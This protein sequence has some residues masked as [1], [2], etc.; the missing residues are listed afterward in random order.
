MNDSRAVKRQKPTSLRLSAS[1]ATTGHL[2]MATDKPYPPPTFRPEVGLYEQTFDVKNGT[3]KRISGHTRKSQR[4]MQAVGQTTSL[5]RWEP[6]RCYDRAS[7]RWGERYTQAWG[8]L[9]PDYNLRNGSCLETRPPA[10]L[11]AAER[12]LALGVVI[13]RSPSG[14]WVSCDLVEEIARQVVGYDHEAECKKWVEHG[15]EAMEARAQFVPARQHCLWETGAGP[16]LRFTGW[17][18][19]GSETRAAGFVLHGSKVQSAHGRYSRELRLGLYDG[20][21]RVVDEH[22]GWP[23]LMNQAEMY[24]FQELLD[25]P[26]E[27]GP[28][29][30]LS[31]CWAPTTAGP[32]SSEGYMDAFADT[33]VSDGLFVHQYKDK[34]SLQMGSFNWLLFQDDTDEW[35]D[36]VLTTTLLMTE[37]DVSVAEERCQDIALARHANARTQLDGVLAVVI[38]GIDDAAQCKAIGCYERMPDYGPDK[39]V[40]FQQVSANN[41][42][43]HLY[44]QA[45]CLEW[46]FSD[47]GVQADS[48]FTYCGLGA[49]ESGRLPLSG[50]GPVRWIAGPPG[51]VNV[52]ALRGESAQAIIAQHR[53]KCKEEIAATLAN[54]RERM[55]GVR[56][57]QVSCC[58][59]NFEQCNGRYVYV[60]DMHFRNEQGLHLYFVSSPCYQWYINDKRTVGSAGA[61]RTNRTSLS[62]PT[63]LD[64]SSI[65]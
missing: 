59:D 10:P 38:D 40:N 35:I 34:P 39:F 30:C 13:L 42:G 57:L 43:L 14:F 20:V 55:R 8:V 61:M 21:Y 44:L 12:R 53:A 9:S 16:A 52:S 22:N 3:V 56:A 49:T 63:T 31:P 25:E 26:D 51:D 58:P 54:V 46:Q 7:W 28:Y 2:R 17:Y 19:H 29:W 33:T 37:E 32:P 41:D 4:R 15:Q 27:R 11:V 65:A 48:L 45:A 47:I 64:R 24:C 6:H 23:I 62:A 60:E 50:D 18:W 1:V 36:H 5:G